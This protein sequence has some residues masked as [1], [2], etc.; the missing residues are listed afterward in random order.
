[1]WYRKFCTCLL[2]VV[3]IFNLQTATAAGGHYAVDDATLVDAGSCELEV[4]Y[5]RTDSS[6]SALTVMPACNPWGNLELA[7]GLSRVSPGSELWVELAAKTLMRDL[8]QGGFGWGLA[9]ATL[10]SDSLREFDG[11]VI[12]VPVSVAISDQLV[13]HTN[14]GWGHEAK[15]DDAAVW[16]LGLDLGVISN[17]NLIAETYG[18]HRGGTEAQAG[19]RLAAGEGHLDFSYGR[20]VSDSDDDWLTLGFAWAF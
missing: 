17:I 16:G 13:L 6:V 15:D 9:L 20:V 3:G 19:V 2:G 10:H 5:A 14:L 4:W 7:V 12:Y 8:E 11:A 18:T 1:M